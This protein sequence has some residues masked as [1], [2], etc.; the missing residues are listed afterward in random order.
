[1]HLH[2]CQDCTS[3][4]SFNQGDLKS[5]CMANNSCQI[6]I[7]KHGKSSTF[8]WIISTGC[9]SLQPFQAQCFAI[10]SYAFLSKATPFVTFCQS[11]VLKIQILGK[12]KSSNNLTSRFLSHLA[13][14]RIL[15]IQAESSTSCYIRV[16]EEK[17]KE[18][19]KQAQETANRKTSLKLP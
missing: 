1:M 3:L 15:T 8:I 11:T 5:C 16:L 18:E 2:A 6:H 14:T 19:M 17:G 10:P 13:S 12:G 9:N 7:V 4:L